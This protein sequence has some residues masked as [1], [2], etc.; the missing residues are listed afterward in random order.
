L[1]RCGGGLRR[2]AALGK[3]VVSSNQAVLVAIAL[4]LMVGMR[5]HL[6]AQSLAAV[7][8]TSVSLVDRLAE[9]NLFLALFNLIPAFPWTAAACCVPCWRP[10]SAM[11]CAE[12][13]SEVTI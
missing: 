7:E 11:Y 2:E 9:V 4:V 8:S 1:L 5:A 6:D 12:P 13:S 3:L 10:A